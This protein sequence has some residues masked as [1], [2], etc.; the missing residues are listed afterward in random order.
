[1]LSSVLRSEQAV[2]VNIQIMRAFV[3][4]RRMAEKHR[5]LSKRLDALEHKYDTQLRE[6]F[7]ILKS[8]II[9]PEKPKRQ[10]GFKKE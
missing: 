1:M 8:M 5:D 2:A 7:Q 3:E 10:I 4:I 6:V 9:P